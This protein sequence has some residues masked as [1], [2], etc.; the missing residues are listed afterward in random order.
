LLSLS[1]IEHAEAPIS[2]DFSL[3]PPIIYAF[4][5][6]PLITRRDSAT[7]YALSAACCYAIVAR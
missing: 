3:P 1:A 2:I 5:P 4:M 7:G 6:L